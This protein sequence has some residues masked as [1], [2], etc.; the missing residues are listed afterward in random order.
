[1]S[2]MEYYSVID[3]S[4]DTKVHWDSTKPVEVEQARRTF[5]ELRNQGYTAHYPAGKEGG[6]AGGTMS[7]FDPQAQGLVMCPQMTAG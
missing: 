4:G 5:N 1:M 7:D 2:V 3:L 6:E